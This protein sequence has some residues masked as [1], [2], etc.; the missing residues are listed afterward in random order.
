MSIPK[1]KTIMDAAILVV[2]KGMMMNSQ[3][4]HVSPVSHNAFRQKVKKITITVRTI[5]VLS[6]P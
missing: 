5:A 4:T 2:K 3:E 6:K 1:L